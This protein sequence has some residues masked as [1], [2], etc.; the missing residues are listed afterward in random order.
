MHKDHR[1]NQTHRKQMHFI[2]SVSQ[3]AQAVLGMKINLSC[4][5]R[6]TTSTRQEKQTNQPKHIQ[7]NFKKTTPQP[8]KHHSIASRFFL[9]QRKTHQ[10]LK[11]VPNATWT[12]NDLSESLLTGMMDLK[13][14][15][16]LH[17]PLCY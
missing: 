9:L 10:N 7:N 4:I 17:S 13:A 5:Y 15:W 2:T 12:Q 3:R 8:T 1:S 6:F 16:S 11:A 14:S